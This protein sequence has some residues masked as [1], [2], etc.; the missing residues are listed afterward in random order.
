MGSVRRLPA[1]VGSGDGC[2]NPGSVKISSGRPRDAD[3]DRP[4][5]RACLAIARD[6][7]PQIAIVARARPGV[8]QARRA[9]ARRRR[10]RARWRRAAPAPFT[11]TC[12]RNVARRTALAEALRR[13]DQSAPAWDSRTPVRIRQAT[14][15]RRRLPDLHLPSP[16][17]TFPPRFARGLRTR[18]RPIDT[19]RMDEA[20]AGPGARTATLQPCNAVTRRGEIRQQT[21]R[22]PRIIYL[23]IYLLFLITFH[24]PFR[25]LSRLCGQ[26]YKYPQ[27]VSRLALRLSPPILPLPPA[28]PTHQPTPH[29]TLH[30]P[31]PVSQL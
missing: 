13:G 15:Q 14:A 26:P 1:R 4:Q 6:D 17:S 12:L 2:R 18:W 3:A 16:P 30:A 20:A 7:D 10:A 9:Q 22:H 29:T 24:G 11:P 28:S 5:F 19:I 31:A 23:F 8:A 25:P 21:P 27:M